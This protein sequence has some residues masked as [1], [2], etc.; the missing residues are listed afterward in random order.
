MKRD[1]STNGI[2]LVKKFEGLQLKAYKALPTE[3][4]YTIGY[5]H[6]GADVTK[7]M[8]ITKEQAEKLLYN[9]LNN[10]INHV[11]SYMSKYDFNQ[12]QF[13]ALVSF[14]YN[15]GNINQLTKNGTRS[16]TQISAMIPSYVKSGGK[17]I[18]GLVNRRK[19][20]KEL[21]DKKATVRKKSDEEVA[22]EVIAGKWG[23]GA[24]RK[25]KLNR[26]G[27]NYDAIQKIVNQI[28]RG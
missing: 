10:A 26:A 21:F 14:T 15:V 3:R 23:N 9:D 4:Y 8:V 5:G 13:D 2:D 22:M 6:Y 11:N 28:L 1:I 18:Q 17:T 19:A 7:G 20:E 27:Y 16:L 25:T 24:T 12:N